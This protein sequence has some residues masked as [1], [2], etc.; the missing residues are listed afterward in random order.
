MTAR[1]NWEYQ[2]SLIDYLQSETQRHHANEDIGRLRGCLV[3]LSKVYL[4]AVTTAHDW[5]RDLFY[6]L[7]AAERAGFIDAIPPPEM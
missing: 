5:E 4:L 7:V 2:A 6:E 1:T 3:E